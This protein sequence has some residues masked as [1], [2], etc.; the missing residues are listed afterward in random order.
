MTPVISFQWIKG[1]MLSSWQDIL[2]QDH[3]DYVRIILKLRKLYKSWWFWVRTWLLWRWVATRLR[4]RSFSLPYLLIFPLISSLLSPSFL[5]WSISHSFLLLHSS[6]S[7]MLFSYRLIF[8][9]FFWYFLFVL[10]LWT[11]FVLLFSFL[12]LNFD[13]YIETI[14]LSFMHT[15]NS[16]ISL[17]FCTVVDNSIIFNPP[18]STRAN[19]SKMRKD[20]MNVFLSNIETKVLNHDWNK[21][22]TILWRI[23]VGW[24]GRRWNWKS[25]SRHRYLELL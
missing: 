6:L 16:M 3:C 17:L 5:F 18:K 7:W 10:L 23:W 1:I 13:R 2:S 9:L 8:Y 11:S 22:E 4:W 25:T 12:L 14:N 15:S 24:I 20:L 21:F 19:I